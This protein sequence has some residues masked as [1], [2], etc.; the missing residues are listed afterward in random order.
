MIL[1]LLS[2]LMPLHLYILNYLEG[3]NTGRTYEFDMTF[4]SKQTNLQRYCKNDQ[5]LIEWKKIFLL[6]YR[7]QSNKKGRINIRGLLQQFCNHNIL[8]NGNEQEATMLSTLVYITPRN[9]CT[10]FH[11]IRSSIPLLQYYWLIPFN[12]IPL[13]MQ[14]CFYLLFTVWL[15]LSFI[16]FYLLKK[17]L[18]CVN[19]L[20]WA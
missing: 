11:C 5:V 18:F 4:V 1:P 8:D 6:L 10:N 17:K 12:S 20:S 13:F 15:F 3:K 9:Y 7:N 14:C 19:L 2:L 16:S